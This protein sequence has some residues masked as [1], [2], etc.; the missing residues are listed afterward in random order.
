MFQIALATGFP[1]ATVTRLSA[2]PANNSI[3][4]YPWDLAHDVSG[5]VKPFS[6]LLIQTSDFNTP[7]AGT[8]AAVA[9]NPADTTQLSAP[10]QLDRN[11][12]SLWPHWPSTAFFPNP[13]DAGASFGVLFVTDDFLQPHQLDQG[14]PWTIG[15][16]WPK[17]L[18]T[19]SASDLRR[20]LNDLVGIPQISNILKSSPSGMNVLQGIQGYKPGPGPL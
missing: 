18:G 8:G 10:F 14:G 5:I 13:N 4:V 15:T 7:G 3:S 9:I 12:K 17:D 2:L 16:K 20:I 6:A 1:G 11:D 19:Y